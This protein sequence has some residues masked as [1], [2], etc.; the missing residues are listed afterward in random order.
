MQ[1]RGVYVILLVVLLSLALF[2]YVFREPSLT[3]YFAA[4]TDTMYSYEIG[5][6]LDFDTLK[7]LEVEKICDKNCLLFLWSVDNFVAID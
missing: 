1:K 4:V 2:V 5:P 7:K 6:Y 3:G